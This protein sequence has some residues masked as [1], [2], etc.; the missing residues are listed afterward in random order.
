M[1]TVIVAFI[2]RLPGERQD[3]ERK[4]TMIGTGSIAKWC[5]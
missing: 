3:T 4:D 1:P 2:S 5:V